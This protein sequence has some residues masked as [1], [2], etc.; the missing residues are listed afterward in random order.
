MALDHVYPAQ[1][2]FGLPCPTTIF[3]VGMFVWLKPKAPWWLL[4]VPLLWSGIGMTAVVYFGVLEDAML[5]IA[6]I[7]AAVL[8]LIKNRRERTA[9]A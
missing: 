7:S 1:P 3:T 9:I 8:I 6:T 4:I 5:P 2:T